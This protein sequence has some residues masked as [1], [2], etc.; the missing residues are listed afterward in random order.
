MLEENLWVFHALCVDA[1][2][3]RSAR[4]KAVDNGADRVAVVDNYSTG[5]TENMELAGRT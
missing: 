1:E 5:H 4:G 3:I 2:D